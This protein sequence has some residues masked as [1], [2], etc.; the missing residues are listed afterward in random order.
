[1]TTR[2]DPL[3]AS[4]TIVDTYQRYLRSL[5][6]PRDPAL[7]AALHEAI[8]AAVGTG[9]TRGPLLEATPPYRGSTTLA[10][11]AAEGVVHAGLVDGRIRVEPDRPL[12]R[13]QEQAIRKVA[14]GRNLIVATGTGSGKT[15]SFLLPILSDLAAERAQ[16]T[17]GPGV[18][19]LLLYPMNALA[20]DQMKRL[21]QLLADCP[22]ITFGRYT[23]DTKEGTNEARARFELQNPGERLLP[24]ELLSRQQMRA[25]P[26]HLL[27]TNYAMLEYLLLRPLDLSLFQGEH[28]GHW[29]FIVVDEAHV[30]DGTRGAELAYE[31]LREEAHKAR[32]DSLANTYLK[33]I[34]TLEGR[35]LIGLLA[36][37]NILPKYGFPVDTVEMRVNHSP[38]PEA[39]QIELSRDLTSA[40]YEYAPGAEIV[41]GGRLWTSAGV[42]R[43]PNRDLERR[44]YTVCPSCGHF[45]DAI[46]NLDPI[47]PRCDTPLTGMPRRYVLPEHGFVAARQ[48]RR[49]GASPPR[50]AWH[51]GTHVVSS[52]AEIEDYKVEFPGGALLARS[53]TRGQLVS[54]NDGPG[55]AGYLICKICGFGQSAMAKR[56][57]DHRHPLTD[58]GCRGSL[59]PLSL[60]HKYETDVLEITVDGPV[61]AGV[62]G[63]VW[64]SVLYA[65]VEGASTSLEIARDDIDG[66]VFRNE[67]GGMSMMIFD[68][69]PGGAG[70]VHRIGRYLGT[71]LQAALARV[72]DCECGAET[73]CYRCLRVFRNELFHETLRRGTALDILARLL[74]EPT[75]YAELRATEPVRD[76]ALPDA[77]TYARSAASAPGGRFRVLEVPGFVFETVP[78]GQIDLWEGRIV[79]AQPRGR[80]ERRLDL[81]GQSLVRGLERVAVLMQEDTDHVRR[82]LFGPDEGDDAVHPAG[83]V[84]RTGVLDEDRRLAQRSDLAVQIWPK[85]DEQFAD[86]TG[87]VLVLAE[88]ENT[89][90][91]WASL[92]LP[93]RRAHERTPPRPPENQISPSRSVPARACSLA[94]TSSGSIAGMREAPSRPRSQTISSEARSRFTRAGLWVTT[95]SWVRPD[96]S[97]MRST[98]RSK[99]WG[100][101]PWSISSTQVSS[102]GFGS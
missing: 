80:G 45:R 38:A 50:R 86:R 4:E 82:D 89:L 64:R 74:D 54:L 57:T 91:P 15:E 14:A 10:E 30:Y 48:P 25:T 63:V 58:K 90:R 33:I 81:A 43:L 67:H 97:R 55:G 71:V 68:T 87:V 44:V 72:R 26:P 27:L 19:A 42:Y 40:V 62:D 46:D 20:N 51:G 73:S 76:F 75:A 98:R 52:G 41:A 65:L 37:R 6:V 47:C 60:A 96:A 7:A 66:T 3:R 78:R 34:N 93:A 18:R 1:M 39:S 69:V 31:Q 99:T 84:L 17:L 8:G 23:G 83:N 29:R 88:D 102:G 100:C 70:N 35:D 12:Y 36:N 101:R 11:L 5:I 53:G 59:E 77:V 85:A 2:L 49:P 28:S 24:N 22:E 32:K 94:H 95:R 92:V 21:R 79:L 61:A 16:G 9:I 56:P 13:H